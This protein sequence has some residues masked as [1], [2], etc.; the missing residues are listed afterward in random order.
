MKKAAIEMNPSKCTECACCQLICSLTY[1]GSFNPEKAR[2][3][4]APPNAIE[5][6]DDCK[7]GCVLCTNYC[8]YGAIVRAKE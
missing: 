6:T 3:V 8:V 7:K 2:I 4:L 5:F 1:A